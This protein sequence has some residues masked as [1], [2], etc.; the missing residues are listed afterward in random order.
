MHALLVHSTFYTTLVMNKRLLCSR[1]LAVE[2]RSAELWPVAF[3][4][5]DREEEVKIGP[6]MLIERQATANQSKAHDGHCSSLPKV[7]D[8]R[9]L[10]QIFLVRNHTT[11]KPF[12][13]ALWL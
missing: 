4:I 3:E 13:Y 12:S 9:G 10:P 2:F 5:W 6:H 8:Q 1:A 7:K 11:Y